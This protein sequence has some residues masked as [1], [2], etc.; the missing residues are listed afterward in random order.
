MAFLK[1]CK[2]LVFW[3]LIIAGLVCDLFGKGNS[4]S[5]WMVLY[6]SIYLLGVF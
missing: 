2:G 4:Y 1:E 5:F 6:L 3:T